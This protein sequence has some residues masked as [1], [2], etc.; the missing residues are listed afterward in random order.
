MLKSTQKGKNVGHCV[1]YIG[2]GI[3]EE[4]GSGRSTPPITL[5]QAG[6]PGAVS[7]GLVPGDRHLTR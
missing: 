6:E 5:W 7:E 4:F 1:R 2:T 3:K